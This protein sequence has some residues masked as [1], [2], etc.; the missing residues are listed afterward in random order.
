[1]NLNK[2][3]ACAAMSVALGFGAVGGAG[4]AQAKPHDPF[5]CA[6]LGGNCWAPGDPPGHNPWG[7][8]G[9]W[10][11]KPRVPDRLE[12]RRDI[13]EKCGRRGMA[14]RNCQS[15]GLTTLSPGAFGGWISSSRSRRGNRLG[16]HY[17]SDQHTASTSAMSISVRRDRVLG[18]ARRIGAI[19]A[20]WTQPPFENWS[21]A[22]ALYRDD[23]LSSRT[24][25]LGGVRGDGAEHA[26]VSCGC[27]TRGRTHG[28]RHRR[29]RVCAIG[30][31]TPRHLGH[32]CDV[33]IGVQDISIVAELQTDA[34]DATL[35][36]LGELTER[37]CVLGQS[38]AYFL[39]IGIRKRATP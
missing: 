33:P 23:P 36:K 1:M 12:F 37:Y 9:R 17:E 3:A 22:Q 11:R 32:S 16:D 21:A 26:P 18:S 31:S 6:G 13:G 35:A 29:R 39:S 14:L 25:W 28:R 27:S 20:G 7:P 30:C 34:D 15:F 8:P 19:M 10:R 5:P 2:V 4:L 38:L 24:R